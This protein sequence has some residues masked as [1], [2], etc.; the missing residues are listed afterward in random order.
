MSSKQGFAYKNKEKTL[1]H[2]AEQWVNLVLTQLREKQKARQAVK[3]IKI[4]RG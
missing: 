4:N 3:N 1:E 2:I